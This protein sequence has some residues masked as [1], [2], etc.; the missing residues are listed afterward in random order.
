MSGN[1]P[2]RHHYVPKFYLRRFVCSDDV[3]KVMVIERHRDVLVADRKSIDRIGYQEALYDYVDKGEPASIESDLNRMFESPFSRSSTWL[4]I[5]IG[6]CATLGEQ[7][8]LPIYM[9]A[10]HLQRRNIKTLR[11]IERENARVL[12]GGFGVDFSEEERDMHRCIAAN[13]D[14]T[15]TFF[16]EGALDRTL[17]VDASQINV[18]VCQSPIALRSSTNPTLIISHPGVKSV[19]G[20]VFNSLRTWWLTLNR[21]WGAFIIAGGPHGFSNTAMPLDAARVINRQYI[22]QHQNSSTV[23]YLIA[24]DEH[25]EEDLEWA[26]YRFEQRIKHGFRYRKMAEKS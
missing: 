3:N 8:K 19:F 7:D 11:F 17:P 10:R 22:V 18:M 15:S 9:F 4:K 1:E 5:S 20:S 2:K 16:R 6:A 23:R 12:S 14:V 26:G 13:A 21:Y 25:L 24:D